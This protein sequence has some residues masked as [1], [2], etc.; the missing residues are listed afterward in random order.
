M[1]EVLDAWD[2]YAC[3]QGELAQ[4]TRVDSRSWGLEAGLN[5]A[6][7]ECVRDAGGIER[8]V[9]SASRKERHRAEL[10][11]KYATTLGG[12]GADVEATVDAR[13]RLRRIRGTVTV[14][15]WV[16]LRAVGE[17]FKYTD[18]A[19]RLKVKP[20]ALRA[21]VLRLRRAITADTVP[22]ANAS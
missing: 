15:E 9:Q 3:L 18:I 17:G 14:E 21:R 22:L 16:L 4:R 6:L 20:G 2:A 19:D 11:R 5:H 10:L 1:L 13:R 8:A 7:T 12:P